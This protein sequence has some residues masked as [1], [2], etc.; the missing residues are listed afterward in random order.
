[1][2]DEPSAPDTLFR[3]VGI[4]LGI[5]LLLYV[6]TNITPIN[7]DTVSSGE[8]PTA[9]VAY[10]ATIFSGKVDLASVKT[11][12]LSLKDFLAVISVVFLGGIFWAMIKGGEVHHHEHEKYKAIVD[13]ETT[14]NEKEIQWQVILDHVNGD[15]P[16]EW[17][18]AILEADN[19]LDEVLEDMGYVGDTVADKLKAMSRTKIASYDALWDAH[20]LRNEIAH[21]GAV[22]MDLS[23]KMARDAVAKFENAF[24]ELG[25]L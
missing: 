16:A 8:A 7:V 18:I 12:F 5:A 13:E 21:G 6:T 3:D 10:I 11:F 17:K 4:V 24:K 15:N 25:Y 19:I 1:M 23:K 14:T 9:L 20:K 2:H 22:D